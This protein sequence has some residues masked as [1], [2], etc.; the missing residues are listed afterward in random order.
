MYVY[1][2]VCMYVCMYVSSQTI[3]SS[4]AAELYSSTDILQL[5]VIVVV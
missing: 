3:Y 1:M 4:T 5:H 2:Y